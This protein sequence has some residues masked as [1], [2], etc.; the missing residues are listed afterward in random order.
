MVDKIEDYQN[1]FAGCVCLQENEKH[2][3]FCFLE[4]GGAFVSSGNL[5][6]IAAVSV[7]M[8]GQEV[9]QKV[10]YRPPPIDID[11]RGAEIGLPARKYYGFSE[12][13]KAVF[14]ETLLEYAFN[15][16]KFSQFP[17]VVSITSELKGLIGKMEGY[18]PGL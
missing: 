7:N 4:P 15:Q 3:P 17:S 12:Y 10:S 13:W 11:M 16:K 8:L 14:G 2:T 9:W 18:N 5:T 1:Y 6:D